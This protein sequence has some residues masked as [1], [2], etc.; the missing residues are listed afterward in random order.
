MTDGPRNVGVSVRARLQNLA[1]QRNVDFQLLLTHYVLE[2]LLYRISI[3]PH[4]QTFVLKG[5][6]LFATWLS[7]PFRNTRDLDLLGYGS[8][9][10]DRMKLIFHDIFGLNIPTDDGVRFDVDK[11]SVAPI[12]ANTSYGG[13]QVITNA[14]IGGARLPVRVDIGFGD[15][16][17]PQPILTDYPVLL[18]FPAP[19][20]MVYPRETVVA[21][22]FEAIV[23][24]G[25]TN[26]RMKDFYDLAYVAKHFS[27]AGEQLVDAIKATFKRR[28]TTL[29]KEVPVALT[30]AFSGRAETHSLWKAFVIREAVADRFVDF[31][32]VVNNI[33]DFLLPPVRAAADERSFISY[34]NEGGLWRTEK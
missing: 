27:F 23:A 7:D 3:S 34:W 24:L 28:G 29:P 14:T 30:E 33:K 18:D 13:L 1:R 19:K 15:A 20:L 12:R 26:I 16:V 5:A 4:A 17:T 6:M 2:R 21:E 9:D 11:L 10:V 31:S 8:Q 22:K 25:L 32:A